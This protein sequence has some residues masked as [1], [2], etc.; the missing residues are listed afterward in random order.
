[1]PILDCSEAFN[2]N[3]SFF[4]RVLPNMHTSLTLIENSLK[5]FL[6]NLFRDYIEPQLRSWTSV[7]IILDSIAMPMLKDMA[8]LNY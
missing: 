6:D 8:D 5:L 4:Q 1:M 3:G 7:P 2:I